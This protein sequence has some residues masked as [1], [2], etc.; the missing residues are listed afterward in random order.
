MKKS[1]IFLS[2]L[3]VVES[4]GLAF[5]I[6]QFNDNTHEIERL[7]DEKIVCNNEKQENI[8]NNTNTIENKDNQ[9]KEEKL[10][11]GN[12]EIKIVEEKW[13]NG[14]LNGVTRTGT[15]INNVTK[16]K[17]DIQG[18]DDGNI[19]AVNVDGGKMGI[20]NKKEGY[21]IEPK[22]DDVSCYQ[23]SGEDYETCMS[24]TTIIDGTKLMSLKTGKII[25]N[26]DEINEVSQDRFIAKKSNKKM[27]YTSEAKELLR[28]D[29]IG[30]IPEMGAY[31]TFDNNKLQ[32]YTKDL[33]STTLSMSINEA[34]TV[35]TNNRNM[36]ASGDLILKVNLQDNLHFKYEGSKYTGEKEVLVTDPCDEETRK[37][38]VIDNN[39]LVKLDNI[40]EFTSEDAACN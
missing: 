23:H 37:I 38:Y 25:L 21:I 28:K 27:L 33:K 22:Y 35:F 1:V 5:Y 11:L 34:H 8:N 16:E 4:L 10:T 17:W 14:E 18:M 29:Y 36:W 24:Y 15:I 30:Y 9:P 32:M 26:T 2:I 12:Y 31:I 3:V 6:K 40:T 19:F 39:K 13:S 20:Y 7:K